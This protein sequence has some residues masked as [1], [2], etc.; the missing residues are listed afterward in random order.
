MG[1]DKH[2]Y[3]S[4]AAA[5][6]LAPAHALVR[7]LGAAASLTVVAR[8]ALAPRALLREH[9]A[10]AGGLFGWWRTSLGVLAHELARP[11][12]AREGRVA[13]TGLAR[14]ALA[15]KVLAA[16]VARPE[17]AR[18]ARVAGSRGVARALMKSAEE[19]RAHEVSPTRVDAVAPELAAFARA[20]EL[21]LREA[22]LA[23]GA[24]VLV[25]ALE[26]LTSEACRGELTVARL[27]GRPL[28]LLDVAP[29][30]SREARLLGALVSLASRVVATLPAHDPR[31]RGWLVEAGLV[32]EPL[33]VGES[34]AA[35][36]AA[37]LFAEGSALAPP[38]RAEATPRFCAPTEA[39]ECVEIA[40]RVIALAREGVPLRRVA[41]A[42][43]SP[44]LYV[45]PL[46]SALRRARVAAFYSPALRRHRPDPR[47]RA[48]LALLAVRAEGLSAERFSEY[49]SFDELPPLEAEPPGLKLDDLG[50]ERG[51]EGARSAPPPADHEPP[52]DEPSEAEPAREPGGSVAL[53]APHRFERLLV[54]AAVVGGHERWQRR[55]EGLSARLEHDAVFGATEAIR[56]RSSRMQAELA[57]LSRFALPLIARLAALPEQATWGTWLE[58][59]GPLARC[60]LRAPERVLAV[61]DELAP[62]AREGSVS[63]DDVTWLLRDRLSELPRASREP[64]EQA[65]LVA[66]PEELA[67]QSF[68]VVFAP[69]LAERVFPARLADDP[70]LP[71]ATRAG[72]D[73]PLPTRAERARA[74]RG[75]LAL[76]AGAAERALVWSFPESDGAEGRG[77]VPSLY[78]LELARAEEGAVPPLDELVR[79]ARAAVGRAGA[80][81]P[82]TAALAIDETEHDL[83]VL[84]EVYARPAEQARG[85]ARSLL[86]HPFVARALRARVRRWERAELTLADGVFPAACPPAARALERARPSGRPLSVSALEVL[87]VCPYRYYL[88]TVLG[89]EPRLE[90]EALHALGPTERGLF[91]HRLLFE[92]FSRLRREGALP[93][94]QARLGRASEVLDEL[95]YALERSP[96]LDALAPAVPAIAHE[97]VRA[98]A[99]ELRE[100]LAREVER[101]ELGLAQ[102][103]RPFAFEL[104]FGA[105]GRA[106]RDV[107]SRDEPVPIRARALDELAREPSPGGAPDE[108]G[109][110]DVALSLVGSIDVV[111]ELA[112]GTLRARDYKTGKARVA[113]G[114]R[115]AGGTMLQPALYALA[116]EVLYPERVVSSG[117][118]AYVT[119]RGAFGA[120]EVPLDAET[121]A[122]VRQVV[123][124]LEVMTVKGFPA[125]PVEGAC[126]R[127]EFLPVCGPGE[128]ERTKRKA[129]PPVLA[130]V[131]KLR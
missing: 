122:G 45:S 110:G 5:S 83:A 77:R 40:R 95:A 15:A 85:L 86:A 124:A 32:E 42:L 118:L 19:L 31:A 41:I 128:E 56:A 36:V 127:C 108:R 21:A 67:G 115:L 39:E 87:A 24:D 47:G 129:T 90:V 89:L 61:L 20:Y 34:R 113:P 43:R 73:L 16:L 68:E 30:T 82:P 69:G 80:F 64:L 123:H 44:E 119:S 131:R 58:H 121:R 98:L 75:L 130:G 79:A 104:A 84:R 52:L 27:A 105:K 107:A 81:G 88:G 50:D 3:V 17:H 33:A 92:L 48:F 120:H 103:A 7:S 74:E 65:V 23:T 59:L 18:L 70:L 100:W 25:A 14:E 53:R 57:V 8:G 62:M 10:R 54:E 125:L 63:L 93:L 51:D 2:L 126:E 106:E 94:S 46:E 78:A 1:G 49:L 71:E 76:A 35:R 117:A 66:T 91:A 38:G 99:G 13:A 101:V 22:R 96:E 29:R 116:L 109:S 9:A 28:V 12:L 55:L 114:A 112:D 102:A 111:D 37:R 4:S 6:R 60:S 72:L 26:A 11:V 97:G